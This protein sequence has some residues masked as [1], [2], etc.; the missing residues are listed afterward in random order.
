MVH[1][2]GQFNGKNHPLPPLLGIFHHFPV[3][4]E[5]PL[6]TSKYIFF[7]PAHLPMIS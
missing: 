6:R 2:E 4:L 1:Y 7:I 3:I 5:I